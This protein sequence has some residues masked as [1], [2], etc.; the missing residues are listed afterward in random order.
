MVILKLAVVL[1]VIGAGA[2]I[3]LGGAA[4][5]GWDGARTATLR[6]QLKDSTI[7]IR[8]ALLELDQI[9]QVRASGWVFVIGGGL[10]TGAGSLWYALTRPKAPKVALWF[11]G[12]SAQVTVGGHW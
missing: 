2:L 12:R 11:D 6:N 4:F 10:I 8:A 1:L 5:L 7:N 3:V 9:H